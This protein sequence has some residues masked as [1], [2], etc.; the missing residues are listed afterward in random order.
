MKNEKIVARIGVRIIRED[1]AARSEYAMFDRK[2][3]SLVLTGTPRV[4]SDGAAVS[5]TSVTAR[6]GT[7]ELE[8]TGEVSGSIVTE[9]AAETAPESNGQ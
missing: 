9:P 5:A 6:P 1:F 8:L 3:N 4:A 7:D 2:E